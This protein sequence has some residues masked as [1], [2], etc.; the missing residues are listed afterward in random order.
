MVVGI[1][2][3]FDSNLI[4]QPVKD[5]CLGE[6]AFFVNLEVMLYRTTFPIQPHFGI[7]TTISGISSKIP[8][9]SGI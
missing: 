1:F 5:F 3:M 8:P 7:R 9:V 6:S 4:P 2:G